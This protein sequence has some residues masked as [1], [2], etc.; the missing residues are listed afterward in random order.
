MKIK[1]VNK[2]QGKSHRAYNIFQSKCATQV[3]TL[4][5]GLVKSTMINLE[6]TYC[7]I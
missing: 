2:H 6:I 1:I 3:R 4:K 7:N 5:F